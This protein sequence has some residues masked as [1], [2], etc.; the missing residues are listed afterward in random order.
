VL[1]LLGHYSFTDSAIPSIYISN[2]SGS[3]SSFTSTSK[4]RPQQSNALTKKQADDRKALDLELRAKKKIKAQL[5]DPDSFAWVG[6]GYTEMRSTPDGS[7]GFVIF[8]SYRAKNSFGGYVVKRFMFDGTNLL[9][10]GA[11]PRFEEAW[12]LL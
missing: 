3:G 2:N 4:P 10:E 12:K 11:A 8:G 9:I 1:P 5:N 7:N 6:T